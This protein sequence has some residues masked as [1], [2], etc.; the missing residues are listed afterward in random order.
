MALILLVVP[1]SG[2]PERGVE[3]EA[4]NPDING[5]QQ[6]L[7]FSARAYTNRVELLWEFPTEQDSVY[8][9]DIRGVLIVRAEERTPLAMPYR[10]QD[11]TVGDALG[12]G[13]VAYIG[14]DE[15]W[16]D[17]DVEAGVTYYYE[18]F[19]FDEIPNYGDSNVLNATPG[20]MIRA[21]LA[22][23]QTLLNDGRV[24][25]TGG[26]GYEGPL[27]DAE[28]Y[29]PETGLFTEVVD[30]MRTPRF[31]HT[32]TLLGDG[33]VLLLGGYE[34]GFLDTLM[35][36]ELFDPTSETFIWIEQSMDLGRASHTATM[37]D[38]GTVL[39]VGGTDGAN[40]YASAEIFDPE[41]L[42]FTAVPLDMLHARYAHTALTCELAGN[43]QVFVAGGFDGFLTLPYATFY[44]PVAGRFADSSGDEDAEDLL[45]LG[46]LSHTA[47]TLADGRVLLAG[48]FVGTIEAGDPTALCEMFDPL[49]DPLFFST[50]SLNEARSGHAAVLLADGRTMVLGGIDPSL[51]ILGST[52]LFDP[53]A[54]TFSLGESLTFER[55]VPQALVLTDGTVLVT[56][57]NDSSFLF[58]PMPVSTAELYDPTT[59]TFVVIGR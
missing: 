55:T 22:H 41:T 17:S 28:I 40:A 49:G 48:G 59:E 54:E 37:L 34:E 29:D 27:D 6:I 5:P 50:G 4:D 35:T 42:S 18:A 31:D 52:E 3:A 46:R 14:G 2:C 57:G 38:D 47:T 32:A 24:L 26:V 30:E 39:I 7:H 53:A 45:T 25:L 20:S 16:V 13:Q 58:D 9:R 12:R 51:E 56:G 19:T 43:P 44:D 11:Y 10:D 1:L 36:A 15:G 23:S 21:R 33:R 8:N